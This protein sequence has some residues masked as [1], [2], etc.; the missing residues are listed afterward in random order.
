MAIIR[1]KRD[2]NFTVID[3]CV[4][5][6]KQLSFAAIGLLCY[7]LSKPDNWAVSAQ[8]LTTVTE[9]TAKESGINAV[10]NLLKELREVGFLVMKKQKTGEADYFV[11]D[12]PQTKKPNQE[13]PNQEKP[14][15][16][17]PNQEK[18]NQEKP[19]QEK[20][21]VLI[22]T[23]SKQELNNN[24]TPLPP[25]AA[26]ENCADA[27]VA[28]NAT[29]GGGDLESLAD[30][31]DQPSNPASLAENDAAAHSG[32]PKRKAIAPVPVQQVL[33]TY[34]EVLGGRLPNAQLLNDK[35]KRV[36]AGRW[37]EMLNSKD[38]SGKVRF[39]DTA[40]GLAWFAKFF[41]KVAMNP[42]W[43][44]ENDRGWRADLDWILK[45]DNFLR[46]LEWRPK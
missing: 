24:N 7:L 42:H 37:K 9:D 36:I 28:A 6:D 3:N 8:H 27:L 11:F 13:K 14:N 12:V 15:Q 31:A 20:P 19:N 2:R 45:P 25:S 1:A 18:P 4:F 40:S 22:N 39:T 35:R 29:T 5:A 38:P 17:K 33:Q 34:N 44:G 26:D 41:A 46:I 32:S 16:E 10:H 21:D 23:E 43:L 30:I